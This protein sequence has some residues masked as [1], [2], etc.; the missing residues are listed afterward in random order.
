LEINLNIENM[1]KIIFL[2]LANI[3][4]M[5]AQTFD[6][7]DIRDLIK[8]G[9]SRAIKGPSMSLVMLT[10]RLAQPRLA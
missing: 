9:T 1:K 3:L 6:D 8:C 7:E 5:N 2:L 10:L 4:V